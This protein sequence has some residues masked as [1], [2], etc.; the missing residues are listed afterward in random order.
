MHKH[1][2]VH[3][4]I[5]LESG[6]VTSL[7]ERFFGLRLKIE[8]VAFYGLNQGSAKL[9]GS[10]PFLQMFLNC[11]TRQSKTTLFLIIYF[12]PHYKLFYYR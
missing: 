9:L 8:N 5:H 7:A 4:Y 3:K 12:K 10:E 11:E 6:T 2:H 1:K